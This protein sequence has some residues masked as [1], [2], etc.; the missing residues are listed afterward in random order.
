MADPTALVETVTD[1]VIDGVRDALDGVNSNLAPLVPPDGAAARADLATLAARASAVTDAADPASWLQAIDQWRTTLNDLAD[2]AF[3]GAQAQEAMLVRIVQERLPRVAAFLTMVGVIVTSPH[4]PPTVDWVKLRQLASDPGTLVNEDLWDALLGDAGLPGTGRLPAVVVGLLILFP[5]ALLALVRGD[6]QVAPLELPPTDGPGPWRDFRTKSAEWISFTLPLPDF[7]KPENER[8]PRTIFDL[9]ADMTPQFSA[10]LGI[11]S[12]RR[13]VAGRSV[14]D[15]EMWLALAIDQDEWDYDVGQSWIL[16]VTPG[17]TAGFGH[18]ADGWHGAFRPFAMDNLAQPLGPD[19]P[20]IVTF[21]RELPEQAPDVALGPP[22]DTRLVIRDVGL[23]LRVRENHPIVEIG[24]YAH[25][26]SAVL[27]NRWWRTFGAT[28]E[29]FGEGIRFDL[30]LDLAY[31]E[32]KGLQL[33]VSAGLDV[34]FDVDWTLGDRP[35]AANADDPNAAKRGLFDLTIHSIRLYVPIEATQDSFD[36]RAEITFHFSVRFGPVVVVV[37]GLGAWLG[38]W[39]E[40]TPPEK[41]WIGFLPPTGAGLQIQ[42]PG[43]VGGGFLDF[44]GGPNER[45]AGLLYLRISAFEVTAFGIHELT[46]QPGDPRRKTSF[47]MV[48]GIRFSPGIQLGYGFAITGF[49]GLIGINRRADTDALRERLTS[50]AAGN[51]LFAEDPV[52]NAPAI[53]G[54]LGALFPPADGVYVFG[55]TIQISWLSVG[56]G[57]LVRFDIGIFIELPGPTK[58]VLL[59]SARASLPGDT[60]NKVF[61]IRVDVVGLV[62]FTKKVIEFDATLINSHVMEVFKVTGDAA[63]R[64]SWGDRPYVMLAIGG[65]HPDF[66]PEPAV[67]PEMTR[68]ALTLQ[69]KSSILFLRGEAYVAV[70]TNTLQFGGRIEAGL[71]KG[72]FNAV[73]FISLDALIQFVPFHFEV[74]FA[75]GFAVRWNELNLAGVKIKGTVSGPGPVTVTGKFCVEILFW[76]ICWSDSFT[77]GSAPPPVVAAVTST[78]QAMQGELTAPANLSAVGGDDVHVAQVRRGTPDRPVVSPVGAV[79]WTQHRAP[80]GVPLDRFD[81]QPLASPQS[82]TVTASVPGAAP[83]RDWFSPG[84]FAVLSAA[85]ALSRPSFERLD[86]GLV[87]GLAGDHSAGVD[88]SYTVIEIRLPGPPRVGAAITFPAVTLDAVV[89]RTDG[90]GVRTRAPR[91]SVGDET[92]VVR[93]S[94]GQVVATAR[95]QSEAFQRARAVEGHALPE[96]DVVALAGV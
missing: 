67:F 9:V 69:D 43:V 75:A 70:T 76:D 80:F 88:H 24:G 44:T 29:L 78:V 93:G 32:G 73:G 42:V 6:L 54:D 5:Q 61:F 13:V 40:G 81:G 53:L 74:E 94:D 83:V 30:D 17:I 25:G 84:S 34:T 31:V 85:E 11:R 49:G 59:G 58:V 39:A 35:P 50:G 7:A 65:F 52:R 22:Y 16:R 71:H 89:S 23:F 57:K 79:A 18:D 56:D 33:N 60:D 63:F 72:S 90:R 1:L 8:I 82:L 10:T 96:S 38:W 15:F 36:G 37:D 66:N 47:I 41:H 20:V 21:S 51:V 64:S 95:S 27:T 92:I 62:D 77:I 26:L 14:T 87:L 3:G 91:V 4:G 55:P 68:V 45:F 2:H 19:D 28:N 48:I 12:A 86:A 46:G